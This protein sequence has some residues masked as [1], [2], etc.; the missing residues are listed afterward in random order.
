MRTSLLILGAAALGSGVVAVVVA[1]RQ[2]LAN[3]YPNGVRTGHNDSEISDIQR[4]TSE[5]HPT[6]ATKASPYDR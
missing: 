6:T 2:Q 1:S 4:A 3:K 5:T